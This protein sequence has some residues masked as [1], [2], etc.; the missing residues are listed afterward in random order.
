MLLSQQ[1]QLTKKVIS[2][3]KAKGC[4]DAYILSELVHHHSVPA[5][6][7]RHHLSLLRSLHA[8][9]ERPAEIKTER[10]RGEVSCSEQCRA[11]LEKYGYNPERLNGFKESMVC[12]GYSRRTVNHIL[13]A[14]RRDMELP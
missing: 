9:G 4:N 1:E 2:Q 3:L 10:V 8:P 6:Y 5:L 13:W 14:A 12:K 7:A 11:H